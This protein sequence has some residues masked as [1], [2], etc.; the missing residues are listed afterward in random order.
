MNKI[1]QKL[2]V[3]YIFILP[4][5][6][7]KYSRILDL[8]LGLIF[9]SFLIIEHRNVK[10]I[11]YEFRHDKL[12]MSVFIF[13]AFM[14]LSIF[15]SKDKSIAINESIR[16]TSYICI[17]ILLKYYKG[18]K[19]LKNKYYVFV[20]QS[21]IISIYGIYQFV[22]AKSGMFLITI[23]LKRIQSFFENPN[24][25]GAYIIILFFTLLIYGYSQKGYRKLLC[26]FSSLLLLI[27]L[28][29]TFSR[30][31]WLAFFVGVVIMIIA[32]N[33]KF[34]IALPLTGLLVYLNPAIYKR[35]LDLKDSSQNMGRIKIWELSLK[36]FKDHKIA[37]IGNGNFA[38]N[39]KKYVQLYTEL[40]MQDSS[41]L[42]VHNSY[43]KVLCELGIIGITMFFVMI[44]FMFTRIRSSI[45]N[46]KN[47]YFYKG[48]IISFICFLF[49]NIF[50]NLFFLPKI[51][52]TLWFLLGLTYENN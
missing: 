11:I 6:A 22:F 36:M 21:I 50:E 40:K 33:W 7:T 8:L 26:Y 2:L 48:F 5:I 25:F 18:L 32:I 20:F 17:L 3:I 47:N 15:Y 14:Y 38:S 19:D 13:N 52:G 41:F 39:Y 30:N 4:F 51:T 1:V 28:I 45:K 43:L 34:I 24:S 27:N 46:D 37:G 10:K 23:N 44:Y 49:M 42:P 31:S 12:L 16:F 29:L 35:L 9:L